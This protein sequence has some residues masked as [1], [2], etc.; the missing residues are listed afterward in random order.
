MIKNDELEFL[1]VVAQR[2]KCRV[3]PSVR[4]LIAQCGIHPKRACYL[5][6]KWTRNGW[7]EYGVSLDLGWITEKGD[8][9]FRVLDYRPQQPLVVQELDGKK[10]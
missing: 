2:G 5:L 7:Y 6:E 8:R 3:I 4:D 10:Q 1:R 9:A